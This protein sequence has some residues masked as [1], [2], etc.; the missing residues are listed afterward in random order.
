V[1]EHPYSESHRKREIYIQNIQ[2]RIFIWKNAFFAK[3][4]QVNS[5]KKENGVYSMKIFSIS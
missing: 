2:V 5:R 3:D 1:F 4:L